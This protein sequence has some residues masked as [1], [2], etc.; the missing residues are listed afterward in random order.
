MYCSKCGTQNNEDDRFCS[1]CGSQLGAQQYASDNPPPFNPSQSNSGS[2]SPPPYNSGSF[3]SPPNNLGNYNQPQYNQS[4]NYAPPG[5]NYYNTQKV[6]SYTALSIVSLFFCT[7]LGIAAMMNSSQSKSKLASGD[8]NGAIKSANTAKMC[9]I[10]GLGVGV[11]LIV[12]S[13]F[14]NS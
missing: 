9:A 3:N 11:L 12:I 5:G 4:N 7:P 2:F 6:E 10:I 14:A 13:L 8:V 1:S